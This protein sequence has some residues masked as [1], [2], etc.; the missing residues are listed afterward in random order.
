MTTVTHCRII[1]LRK[2]TYIC[3]VS[4]VREQQEI[5]LNARPSDAVTLA[6]HA[7]ARIEVATGWPASVK[8]SR[9]I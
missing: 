1:E 7:S 6:L 8:K 3:A 2:N 4:L 9:P 5:V